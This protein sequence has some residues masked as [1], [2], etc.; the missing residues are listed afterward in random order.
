MKFLIAGCGS[1]GSR[2]LRNLLELGEKDIIL[3]DINYE[4]LKEL[5]ASFGLKIFTD[6]DKALHEAPDV[7]FI[8][9]P[10]NLHIPLSLRAAKA[11]CHLFI[12]KPL[13]HT[14]AHVDDLID[15]VEQKNLVTLV[16]CN[17]R[18][19]PCLKFIKERLQDGVIGNIYSID[20][21]FGYYLPYW[22]PEQDYRENYAAKKELGGGIILDDIHELDLL[23]WLIDSP[24]TASASMHDK[25]SDLEIETEDIAFSIFKFE[26][27]VLGGIRSD[28]LQKSYSRRCKI[29]GERGS[30][31]WNW[32]KNKVIFEDGSG[33]RVLFDASNFDTN[34]MYVKEVEYFIDIIKRNEPTF[35]D[36]KFAKNV[37]K[38]ALRIKR[39]ER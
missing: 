15:I 13:S 3:Y 26:N 29:V 28:Y 19:H 4:R 11:G 5:N 30:I 38:I 8:T 2:H 37:L 34:D 18:F 35:N 21:E 36:I 39:G 16:G 12:E 27:G 14:M 9:G 25:V 6:F 33:E 32:A 7:V 17:M 1:I 23:T 31:S 24:V 22:R 10:T 20:L